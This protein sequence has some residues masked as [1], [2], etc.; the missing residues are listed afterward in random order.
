MNLIDTHAHLD[1]IKNLDQA[2]EDADKEGVQSI[3]AVSTDTAS[4]RKNLEIKRTKKNPKIYLAMGMH[5]SD[6]NL[7]DLDACVELIREQRSELVA[8]GEIGLDFWYKWVRKDT[9]KKDAQRKVFRTL[10]ELAGELDLPAV[11]HTRGA[12]RECFEAT[13]EIG[14][15]QAEFHWYSGPVDVLKDILDR[16]YYVS[17]SPSVARSPQSREAMSYAPIEQTMIETD[18]PVFYSLEENKDNG[19][20]AEPKDIFRTLTAYCALK[21]IEEERAVDILN[22]NARDF[23]HLD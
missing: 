18:S 9:E 20:Q 19:F 17:T 23:F 14:I 10:L 2:L 5:P 15:K 8:I 12:W 22:R 7:H 16:G 13:K 6:V 11:I 3:I 21:N 1:H 4:C